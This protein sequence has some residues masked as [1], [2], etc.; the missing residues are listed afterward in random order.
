LKLHYY[1]VIKMSLKRTLAKALTG[2]AL[3]SSL[4]GL[5]VKN[6]N[7]FEIVLPSGFIIETPDKDS[8]TKHSNKLYKQKKEEFDPSKFN[9][10]ELPY[11]KIQ[12]NEGAELHVT[13][14]NEKG[15]KYDIWGWIEH[16]GGGVGGAVV[17]FR[18][19]KTLGSGYGYGGWQWSDS[20]RGD[21]IDCLAR[22]VKKY[23]VESA[24][25]PGIQCVKCLYLEEVSGNLKDY[26][27]FEFGE[28]GY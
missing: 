20:D 19:S 13:Y 5:P 24:Y 8:K 23:I 12:K 25:N 6:A 26:I 28:S 2:A 21:I 17:E 22:A 3:V 14:W 7:A 10:P 4:Y 18:I 27:I 16:W 9:P 1:K 11:C 15:K